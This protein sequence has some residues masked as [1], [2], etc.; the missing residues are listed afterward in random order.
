MSSECP[1]CIMSPTEGA[2]VECSQCQ[3]KSC[4]ECVQTYIISSK[5]TECINCRVPYTY[6]F[7]HSVF[8]VEFRKPHI[9]EPAIEAIYKKQVELIAL[10]MPLKPDIRILAKLELDQ[11]ISLG[12]YVDHGVILT[13][14]EELEERR[15]MLH[16]HQSPTFRCNGCTTGIYTLDDKQCRSCK[17]YNCAVCETAVADPTTHECK[18]SD[19][20]TLAELKITSRR[21]PKCR[22]WISKIE[23]CNQM[24][25][26]ECKTPFNWS[27]GKVIKSGTFFHNPH[28]H[29]H[30][31][32]GGRNVFNADT[33]TDGGREPIPFF[34]LKT[35]DF[36]RKYDATPAMCKTLRAIHKNVTKIRD[37]T[38]EID[39]SLRDRIRYNDVR[40]RDQVTSG[41][42]DYRW[43]RNVVEDEMYTIPMYYKTI[44]TLNNQ[45]VDKVG[46]ILNA[47]VDKTVLPA[48]GL[49]DISEYMNRH[50]NP[51]YARIDEWMG[52][53]PKVVKLVKLVVVVVV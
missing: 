40:Y 51:E 18:E 8:P 17:T 26:T 11:H 2:V 35:L 27:N 42:K 12:R 45:I 52:G 53:F 48:D 41:D 44:Q 13:I 29:A 9:D 31:D 39:R 1:I 32:E 14:K 50:V 20:D 25:C 46:G 21:C 3:Y 30:L 49:R 23:G 38:A 22:I 16:M 15:E 19:L 34:Y 7:I 37:N 47:I 6:P 28:Y 10:E 4:L 33:D 36:R 43:L 24:F 5:K